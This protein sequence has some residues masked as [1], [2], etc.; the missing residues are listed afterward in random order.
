MVVGREQKGE[1]GSKELV[2]GMLLGMERQRSE[3]LERQAQEDA[4]ARRLELLLR[5]L[6]ES[7]RDLARQKDQAARKHARC[8]LCGCPLGHLASAQQHTDANSCNAEAEKQP[9]LRGVARHTTTIE[10][11]EVLW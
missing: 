2:L 9:R 1:P 11:L 4:K 5:G 8:P 6:A 7:R 10:A 3:L